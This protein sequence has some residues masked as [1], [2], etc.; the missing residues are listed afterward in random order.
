MHA[1]C[2]S[3]FQK[4]LPSSAEDVSPSRTFGATLELELYFCIEMEIGKSELK[5][6]IGL[7]S[8]E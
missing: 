1:H 8:N 5:I 6:M 2:T 3:T 4:I 7:E